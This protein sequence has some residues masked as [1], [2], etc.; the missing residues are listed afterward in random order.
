LT[1]TLKFLLTS[2]FY[3]PY[4]V[5]GDAIEVRYLAEELARLGH[6]VHVLHSVD[7]YNLKRRHNKV[8]HAQTNDVITHPIETPLSWS[9]LD[10][11]IFGS[12]SAVEHRF[13]HLVEELKPDVVHHHNISLLGHSILHKRGSYLNLY[14]AHDFWLI[15]PMNDLMRNRKEIC[16]RKTCY[17]CAIAHKRPPQVW[18]KL[19]RGGFQ[20]AIASIDL[21]LSPSEYMRGRLMQ[22]IQLKIL[23]LPNFV[24]APPLTTQLIPEKA[25]ADYF[26]FVGTLEPH[27]GIMNLLHVFEELKRDQDLHL[28]IVGDGSLK[29]SVKRF[30]ERDF[31]ANQVWYGGYFGTEQEKGKLYWLYR[32]AKA[33]VVPS[34]SPEN[35][36][37]VALEALS[38]GTPVIGTNFGGL[39]EIVG[40]VDESL[41]FDDWEGLKSILKEFT[42][43]RYPADVVK[44]VYESNFSPGKHISNY[45]DVVRSWNDPPHHH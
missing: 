8:G 39:P 45:I 35:A 26:L 12:S 44:Q 36:P 28:I 16:H 11:Y 23:T 27:K 43:A 14:T 20:N 41:L 3:P 38:V 6:E 17:S 15:C 5:G 9:A 4:H 32:N 24:P 25:P 13:G 30:V 10:A 31:L 40:K 18:R 42:R 1:E 29:M 19:G 22:E 34:I 2:S 21:I 33:L 37:L 7:A